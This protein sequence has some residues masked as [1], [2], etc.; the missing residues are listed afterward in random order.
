MRV[1]AEESAELN[2]AL[3]VA[4]DEGSEPPDARTLQQRIDSP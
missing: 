4:G 3:L 2:P 1:R